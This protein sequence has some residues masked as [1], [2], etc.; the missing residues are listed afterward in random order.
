MRKCIECGAKLKRLQE[1]CPKCEAPN[2]V[3]DKKGIKK[4]SWGQCVAC[5][6]DCVMRINGSDYCPWHSHLEN[7]PDRKKLW[8]IKPPP[9]LV[10]ARDWVGIDDWIGDQNLE[11]VG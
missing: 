5:D 11:V 9:R 6:L 2:P 3:E 8:H 4:P 1:T 10:W 7:H